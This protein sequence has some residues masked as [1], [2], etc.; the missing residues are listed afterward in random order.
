M[1]LFYNLSRKHAGPL[2]SLQ[3]SV[4]WPCALRRG[5]V[6]FSEIVLSI[7][8]QFTKGRSLLWESL[9]LSGFAHDLGT[10]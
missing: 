2:C 4:G 5:D 9:N 10:L 8:L 7:V 6:R 3:E 1:E